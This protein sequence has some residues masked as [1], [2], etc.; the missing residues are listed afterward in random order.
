MRDENGNIIKPQFEQYKKRDEIPYS[1]KPAMPL[2]L[3]IVIVIL[4][5]CVL[6]LIIKYIIKMNDR[7]RVQIENFGYKFY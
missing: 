7:K 3:I 5:L 2:W 6:Y 4:V 1:L